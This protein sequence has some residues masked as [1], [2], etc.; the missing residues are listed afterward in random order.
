V[1]VAGAE[2]AAR[3]QRSSSSRAMPSTAIH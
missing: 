1:R 2:H 3:P